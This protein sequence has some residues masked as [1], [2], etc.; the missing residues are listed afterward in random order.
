VEDYDFCEALS[1]YKENLERK[2]GNL[3]EKMNVLVT[4]KNCKNCRH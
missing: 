3:I 4:V 2:L 1:E